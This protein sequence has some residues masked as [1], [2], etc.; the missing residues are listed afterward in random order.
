MKPYD[1]KKIEK[2]W[3]KEW[4]RSKQNFT[5]DK[6]A[7]KKNEYLL[8]EFPYPSGN[9]HVGHWYAFAVPDIY[10]RFRRA[11]GKNV[12]YPIGF[13]AFGLPAENAAIKNGLNPRIWTQKNIAYMKKQ[14]AS[15]GA[16]F[17]WSR[18]LATIDPD[19]YKWTQWMFIQ[20]YKKGLAYQKET[21]ANWCPK[22]KTVLANEQVIN[23]KCDRCGSDVEQRLMLQWNLK[24]T[25]YADR[26]I[27]D[28][29]K[30]D[31]PE[32]IKESQRNWIGR[33]EGAEIDFY[34]D[35]G[36]EAINA[37]TGPDG[38]NAHI[39]VFTTRADTLFGATYLVLAP[40][41]PWVTLAIDADHKGVLSNRDEVVAYVKK[42]SKKTDL[43]RQESK[44]KTG[45]ELK[46][47]QA[48]N[49]ATGEK[50]P[51]FVADYVLGHYGT[52]AIMAVP[53]HDE[54]DFEF[55]KKFDLPIKNVVEPMFV[56]GPGND[57]AVHPNER[58]VKRNAICAIVHNPK[59][60]TYLCISWKGVHMHGLVTGGVEDGEDIVEA[61]I[62]EVRE[63]TGYKN[64]HPVRNQN[65]ALHSLFYHRVKKENRWAR[66]QYVMLELENEERDPVDNKEEA[67]HEV[68]WKKKGDLG[69]FFTVIEGQFITNLIDRSDTY[70]FTG[71][72]VL[73]NSG[74]FNWIES[75]E[76]RTSLTQAFGQPK[77][78]YRLR[79]WGV[80]R[81]RYWGVPI[82]IIHCDT[83][84]A[85]PVPDTQLPVKLPAVK[86]Y[87]PTGDGK[88]PLAKASAWVNVKCPMCKGKA[89]RETDTFDTF[90]D[91]S[92]YFLRYA[93]P[94][95]KKVF[96]DKK[97]QK[98]WLPVDLYAG[99]AEH[100]TMHLL[101]SRFW[102]KALFDLKLVSEKEPYAR[103]MNRGLILGPDGAK[104]S[105][106]K[107]NVID[108]DTVVEQLGADTVRMY[109]AFIGPYNEPGS[110]PW[111][112]DSIVGVRRFL[113]RTW[114]LMERAN[115]QKP[116]ANID[117][118]LHQT[119][120]K[121]DDDCTQLK[122]NTAIAQMMTF[123]N[124]A[125]QRGVTKDQY[126]TFV[127]ILAPFAP[128]ITEELWHALG[129]KKS[130]HLAPWPKVNKKKLIADTVTIVVQI[131]GKTR[132]QAM[133]E[134]N[135]SKEMQEGAAREAVA[136]RL[137]NQTIT[138]TIV[139]PG[140]LVNFVLRA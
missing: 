122:F 60:D 61:A 71:E 26:L 12:V 67:L 7:G 45:V 102:H 74:E 106:S 128:H 54:R 65:V 3:Q 4:T 73:Y 110:Y 5:K 125:E 134:A 121:V 83:C 22:D 81:Q 99:G 53:A 135:A 112:P 9:L 50:I 107:G 120:K 132:G 56:A 57:S 64:M 94:K 130:V 118:L 140:R 49:P 70:I 89:Q 78:T 80:S 48:I 40:E 14:L 41:H 39:T 133:V 75:R 6:V 37:R 11:Q 114:R 68:V 44:E 13:D 19:Y 32:Q 113:E 103:R 95:N 55:A 137:T 52:G 20:F 43:E 35:F 126:E 31:W 117:R 17:D 58:F 98:N 124:A 84:G 100:T 101:Y 119:I 108:P 85:V 129:N 29:T 30:L 10:A 138:R 87:M 136:D 76:A 62:R 69:S 115:V 36:D 90:V 47:V 33:S 24:I 34:L 116:D 96:A 88:S 91:S 123:V 59:D 105:K 25:K 97:K 82:P 1:H 104:M 21:P 86:D 46:G 8:V 23:G 92:W 16:S 63:E 139:V 51:M 111:N 15:M 131:N 2:K 18:E 38:K 28:L 109:L 77:K 72:G 93:D 42:S 27:D 127:R 79:D 66:F